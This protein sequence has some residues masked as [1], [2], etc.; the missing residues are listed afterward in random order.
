M[1]VTNLP[2]QWL[3][4]RANGSNVC[5]VL[6][7]TPCPRMQEARARRSLSLNLSDTRVYEPR[8]IMTACPR[9]QEAR[10]FAR[11]SS[12]NLL[13]RIHFIIEMIWW[14][15]LAPWE[16]HNDRMSPHAGGARLR[17]ALRPPPPRRAPP[18]VRERE[19]SLLTTY[20]SES[21]LSS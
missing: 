8:S 10:G 2:G 3:Q 12:D 1:R 21:T 16:I 5:R 11:L 18:I 4:C 14:T 13:V 7:M 19:S 20:W 9:K 15:G 6:I 17:A